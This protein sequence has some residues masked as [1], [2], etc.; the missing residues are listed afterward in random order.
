MVR[1]HRALY[2]RQREGIS[3]NL[4]FKSILHQGRKKALR[5][6]KEGQSKV[7]R[8]NIKILRLEQ[9]FKGY[10]EGRWLEDNESRRVGNWGWAGPGLESGLSSI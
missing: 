1:G 5:R 7:G 9:T 6:F 3:E 8:T 2:T 4:K 10:S